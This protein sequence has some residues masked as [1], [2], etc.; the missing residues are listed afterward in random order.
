MIMPQNARRTVID[1]VKEKLD[2]SWDRLP[3]FDFKK[4]KDCPRFGSPGRYFDCDDTNIMRAIYVVLW[5]DIFPD[6]TLENL[7]SSRPY[8]G[9]TLNTFHTMFGREIPEK[10]GLYAGLEKYSP[11][12]D[13]RN[14][15]QDFQQN[16]CSTLGNFAVLPNC[17]GADTTLNLYRGT[18]HWRD[19]FDRFLIELGRHLTG[20]SAH[21]TVLMQLLQ[22]NARAF[23]SY[24]TP[25]GFKNFLRGLLLEDYCTVLNMQPRTIFIMNYHWM[26]PD[27]RESYLKAAE[28][29]LETAAA[30]IRNRSERMTNLLKEQLA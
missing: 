13:L 1:F 29:Y 7:G 17:Y 30:V 27:D 3:A 2:G 19:F 22:A 14:A 4:L 6:L 20:D 8:R 26:N 10:P 16:I 23:Q 18:N 24:R 21:D 28:H 12:D 15:V 5:Q 11:N 25:E 9:D